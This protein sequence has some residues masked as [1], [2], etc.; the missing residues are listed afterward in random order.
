MVVD[1]GGETGQP[2]ESVDEVVR[3]GLLHLVMGVVA[4]GKADG[5]GAPDDGIEPGL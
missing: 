3:A 5:D 1:V 2:G 4:A